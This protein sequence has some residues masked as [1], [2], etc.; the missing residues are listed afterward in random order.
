MVT[1]KQKR[2]KQLRGYCFM[3]AIIPDQFKSMVEE[4]VDKFFNKK[5]YRKVKAENQPEMVDRLVHDKVRFI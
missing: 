5:I 3:I 2:C 4:S 1:E